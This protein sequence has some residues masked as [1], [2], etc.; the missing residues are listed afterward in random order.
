MNLCSSYLGY[1]FVEAFLEITL[2]RLIMAFSE[3]IPF[4]FLITSFK[5]YWFGEVLGATSC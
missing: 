3:I 5:N 1:R 2:Q 4:N